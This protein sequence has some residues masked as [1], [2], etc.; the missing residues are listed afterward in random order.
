MR[1]LGKKIEI[2]Y[3]KRKKGDIRNSCAN[4]SL[5]KKYLN[6]N[7]KTEFNEGMKNLLKVQ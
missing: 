6:Y 1:N 3:S 5:A 7:L 4:I 2:K